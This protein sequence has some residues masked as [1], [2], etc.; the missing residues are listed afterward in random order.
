MT[1]TDFSK[2]GINWSHKSVPGLICA[3]A[4]R[5]TNRRK[6]LGFSQRDLAN[7]VNVS[8]NTIQSYESGCLPRG[9]HFLNLARSL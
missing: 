1:S 7:L 9:E 6:R 5:L 8:V 2:D 4:Q 3:Y